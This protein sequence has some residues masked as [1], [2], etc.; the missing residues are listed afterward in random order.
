MAP[1]PTASTVRRPAPGRPET[2]SCPLVDRGCRPVWRGRI[3]TVWVTTDEVRP[4]ET[5]LSG[6]A[7]PIAGVLYPAQPAQLGR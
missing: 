5:G 7:G 3:L 4:D 1:A 6:L 2:L